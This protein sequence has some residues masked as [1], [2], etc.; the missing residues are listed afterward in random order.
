M[1]AKNLKLFKLEYSEKKHE[2]LEFEVFS[3]FPRSSDLDQIPPV[4]DQ[5]PAA[6]FLLRLLNQACLLATATAQISV[7]MCPVLSV[8]G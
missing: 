6:K 4:W 8:A 2:I 1:G 7:R 5:N 3:E